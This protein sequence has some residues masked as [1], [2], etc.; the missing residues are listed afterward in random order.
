MVVA[1]EA[2]KL[3]KL[4]RADRNTSGKQLLALLSFE[5]NTEHGRNALRK[6]AFAL[7]RLR[8]YKVTRSI[9]R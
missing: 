4:A 9:S 5:F 2:D 8:R 6:N 7:M 3:L 1:G